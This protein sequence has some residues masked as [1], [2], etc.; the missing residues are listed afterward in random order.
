MLLLA[1]AVWPGYNPFYYVAD[2]TNDTTNTASRAAGEFGN[3]RV[4]AGAG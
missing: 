2:K 3:N 4:C 1:G